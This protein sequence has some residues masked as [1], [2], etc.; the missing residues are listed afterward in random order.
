MISDG[1]RLKSPHKT[2]LNARRQ[3]ATKD[4][5]GVEKPT[6]PLSKSS[7]F[8][9]LHPERASPFIFLISNRLSTFEGLF[10]KILS[11]KMILRKSF[12]RKHGLFDLPI[13]MTFDKY[14]QISQ[15]VFWQSENKEKERKRRFPRAFRRR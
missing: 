8:D 10:S 1:K 11:K 4:C 12:S 9:K 2:Y 6:F 3:I 13:L 5:R 14:Q 15:D 7:G